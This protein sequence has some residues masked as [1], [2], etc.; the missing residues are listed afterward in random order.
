M[1]L[2][3]V[4]VLFFLN[5]GTVSAVTYYFSSYNVAVTIE[6]NGL[7]RE[8]VSFTIA[9]IGEE[10]ISWIEFD[11]M[12]LPDDLLVWDSEGILD[13]IAETQRRIVI[14]L[15]KPLEKG[16]TRDIHISFSIKGVIIRH[17]DENIFTISYIPE[18]DISNFR[19]VVSLPPGSTLASEVKRTGE[20]ISSVYPV[21]SRVFSDGKRIIVEWFRE[22]LSAGEDFRVFLMY[23]SVERRGIS[24]LRGVA[25]GLFLGAVIAYYISRRYHAEKLK[26]ARLVLDEDEK[27]IYDL[28]VSH[29]FIILQE[30]I[31]KETE[32]S[33]AKIS[34]LVRRLEKKGIIKKE[35]Y[36]KTN[37]LLLRKE[38][39][40]AY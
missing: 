19:F 1:R 16:E 18:S 12:A 4:L 22:D 28:L 9:N 37:R 7:I 29:D 32:F 36:R 17:M 2:L 13:Y 26:V 14:H 23:T 8:E 25:V 10:P 40:G 31:T 21:P 35:P 27:R 5:I 6:P 15:R 38:F 20:S 34:K 33:R 3:P 24:G 39:G 11:F 30:D